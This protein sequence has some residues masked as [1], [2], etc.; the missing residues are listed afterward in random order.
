MD[1]LGCT[2]EVLSQVH[3]EVPGNF[4]EIS[5]KCP[6]NFPEMSRKFPGNFPEIPWQFPGLGGA[7]NPGLGDAKN[8]GLEARNGLLKWSAL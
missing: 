6:G 4:L 3:L 5:R 8:P 7:K 2:L 1:F